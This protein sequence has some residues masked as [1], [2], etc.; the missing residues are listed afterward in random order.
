MAVVLRCVAA[1]VALLVLPVAASAKMEDTINAESV[2]RLPLGVKDIKSRK[3]NPKFKRQTVDYGT[4]ERPG[5]IVINTQKRFLYY[6]TGKGKAVRYGIGVGRFGFTWRG[7]ENISKKAEWPDWRA[8]R[9]MLERDPRLP[10]FMRGGPGNPLGAR[11]L[12]LGST[13]YRIHGTAEP[14]SIGLAVSSGCIRLTNEDVQD[15]YK[16]VEIGAKVIVR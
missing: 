14:W 4:S 7:T 6:V 10:A 5:T 9:D 3:I 1:I 8:P 16:R 13:E 15:L 12:Y 2:I 11:A